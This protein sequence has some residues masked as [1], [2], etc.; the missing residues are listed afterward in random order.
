MLDNNADIIPDMLA[1]TITD[2]FRANQRLDSIAIT[3][4][5]NGYSIPAAAV[6]RSGTVLSIPFTTL[7]GI[8]ARPT[9]QV[10][11]V[12]TVDAEEK[13]ESKAFTD[14]VCPA[15]LAAD[16]LEN[17][18]T[19]NDILYLTFTEAIDQN[20]LIGKQLQL[21]KMPDGAVITLDINGI[22]A[23]QNDSMVSVEVTPAT[24]RPV[25][26]DSLRLVP[27]SKG[28]IIAD[29]ARN[30]P[31]DLNRA[32][33]LG[34]RAGP[35]SIISAWYIDGNANGI[36]DSVKIAFKRAVLPAELSSAVI[37]WDLRYYTIPVA[38]IISSGA[39]LLTIPVVGTVTALDRIVTG[40]AMDLTLKF[41]QFPDIIR[42]AP[43]ADSAAPVIDSATLFRGTYTQGGIAVQDTLVIKFSERA[44]AVT[45]LPYI[46]FSRANM[47]EYTFLGAMERNDG[48]KYR[49]VVSSTITPG[50]GDSIWIDHL[51]GVCDGGLTAQRNALN[52]RVLLKSVWPLSQWTI[53]ITFNPF[54]PD[55]TKIPAEFRTALGV[56]APA[57]GV[58]ISAKTNSPIDPALIN[59]SITLYD[60]VGYIVAQRPM[61]NANGGLYFAWDGTRNGRK[62]EVGTY[63]AIIRIRENGKQVLSKKVALGVRKGR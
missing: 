40:G 53:R 47:V 52:R 35:P 38:S 12:M 20:V 50:I 19:G 2:T 31:H 41:A 24:R 48:I 54:D 37:Q 10:A 59:A 27:G 57:Y 3:Y 39:S 43:V 36:I 29:R 23:A 28:G 15:L 46:V 55:T 7:S 61:T 49:Y 45:G 44:P 60:A 25:A 33:L 17:D 26:G 51:A 1:I 18:G 6:T 63:L 58:G 16:V 22:V 34:S 42:I 30:R 11:L 9:G 8:D 5:G 32:V 21:I 56:L 4:R 14:G 13:R 62:V